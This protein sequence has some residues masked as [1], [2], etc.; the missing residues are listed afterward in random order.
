MLVGLAGLTAILF[1]L[2]SDGGWLISCI[3]LLV[4]AAAFGILAVDGRVPIWLFLMAGGAGVLLAI[5]G[6]Y[7]AIARREWDGGVTHR[8]S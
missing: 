4:M 3:T 6:G 2:T 1:F 7:G 5:A 8:G